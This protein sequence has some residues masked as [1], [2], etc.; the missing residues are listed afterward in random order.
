VTAKDTQTAALRRAIDGRPTASFRL[1]CTEGPDKGKVF[2]MPASVAARVLIGQSEVCAIRLADPLVS[3]RHAALE[4]QGP[5]LHVNDLGSRNGTYANEVAI[6]EAFLWGGET[7]RVGGTGFRVELDAEVVATPVSDALHFGR[8]IGESVE[9]RRLYPFFEQLAASTLPILI[10]GETGT[11]KELLAESL[12]EQGPRAGGPF[13]VFDGAQVPANLIESTL[14][15]DESRPGVFE[16]ADRGTLLLDEVGE[17]DPQIQRKLLR[18]LE[19]GEVQRVG[20]NT[21]RKVDVRIVASTRLDLDK[22]V[23]DES[24]REDLYYRLVVSRV[25]LPPL[26]RREGDVPA[27][28]RHFWSELGASGAPSDTLLAQLGRHAWPGNVRELRNRM[29]RLIAFGERDDVASGS[30]ITAASTPPAPAPAPSAPAAGDATLFER[31]LAKDLPLARAREIVVTEF[32]RAYVDRVLAA[33]GGSVAKAAAASGLARRY[34]Q[35]LR[36]KRSPRT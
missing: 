11:G 36:A 35:L 2:P 12:H 3:R 10:E 21:S 19:R 30:S 7:L 20:S 32:E 26:R 18:V 6:V 34:F 24:F 29:A 17:L 31:V 4:V 9:M 1:V 22:L 33:H 25:E 8:L 13:V 5:S 28:A 16:Q 15:G 23:Q 14:F 27:L